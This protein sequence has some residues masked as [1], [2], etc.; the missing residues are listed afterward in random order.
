MKEKLDLGG[1]GLLMAHI[2]GNLLGKRNL[3][4]ID[5]CQL[6]REIYSLFF[7]ECKRTAGVST[8]DLVGRYNYFC[9]ECGS[10]FIF[11]REHHV[12]PS[13]HSSQSL[14]LRRYMYIIGSYIAQTVA[15][16]RE[17]VIIYTKVILKWSRSEGFNK[18]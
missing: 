9:N 18:F 3:N 4:G 2:P 1:C 16:I 12:R 15:I 5:I 6:L 13:V 10:D 14:L 17:F 11:Y 8:T 7:R